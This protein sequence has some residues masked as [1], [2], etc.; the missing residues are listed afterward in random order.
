[1]IEHVTD[2]LGA[3]LDGELRGL[4]LHQVEEHLAKCAACRTELEELRGLS[5]L[6]QETVPAGAFT[7]T[8]RFV[9]NLAL[10]LNAQ[11]AAINLLHRPEATPH[12]K[13]MEILWWLVPAGVLGAWVFLQAV[14]T[15]STLVSTADLTGLFGNAATWLQNG[16]QN[17]VWFSASM[18]LFGNHLSGNGRSLLDVLN[19]LSIFGSSLTIQLAWQ[20]GIGLLLWGWLAFWW[21]RQRTVSH[22]GSLHASSHS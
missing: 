10:R 12:R 4:R 3:Y 14:T 1:M 16:S 19:G 20:G 21:S 5:T 2:L 17:A 8:E 6:L 7:P 9:S 18:S 22:P 15:V 13:P 11:D